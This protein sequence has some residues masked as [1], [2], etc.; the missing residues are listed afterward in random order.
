M[1]VSPPGLPLATL[2]R[3]VENSVGVGAYPGNRQV[4]FARMI[5]DKA[6]FA[7][8]ADVYARESHGS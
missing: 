1:M 4:G 6:T 5:T 7:Y 8:L 3:A 2:Q